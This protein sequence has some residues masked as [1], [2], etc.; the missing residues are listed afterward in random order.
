MIKLLEVEAR[1]CLR[2]VAANKSTSHTTYPL[3]CQSV[4][5]TELSVSE[6]AQWICCIS[7]KV[8]PGSRQLVR[9]LDSGFSSRVVIPVISAAPSGSPAYRRRYVS[10]SLMTGDV[11]H[12][13]Q[14]CIPDFFLLEGVKNVHGEI[15]TPVVLLLDIQHIH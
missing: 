1:E 13:F 9:L 7:N 12:D 4:K 5:P 11:Y 6:S 2:G 10:Y 15:R 8:Q 3:S 14:V